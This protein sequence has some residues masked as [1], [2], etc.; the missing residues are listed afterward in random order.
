MESEAKTLVNMPALSKFK[1]NSFIKHDTLDECLN[2]D[3]K[4][5]GK[6]ELRCL[7]KRKE[8]N[9]PYQIVDNELMKFIQEFEDQLVL[10]VTGL[11]LEFKPN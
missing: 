10:K 6:S 3:S 11:T 2:A 4:Y 9:K 8:D 7:S 5:L 1:S